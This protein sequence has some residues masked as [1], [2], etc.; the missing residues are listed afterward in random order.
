MFNQLTAYEEFIRRSFS[1]VIRG[2]WSV[3]TTRFKFQT[4]QIHYGHTKNQLKLSQT[5]RKAADKFE[6]SFSLLAA[7]HFLDADNYFAQ[8]Y[9]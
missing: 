7:S 5:E 9:E 4:F 1:V 2:I 6:H 3:S 8:W